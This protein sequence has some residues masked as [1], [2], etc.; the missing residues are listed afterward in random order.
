MKTKAKPP[1]KDQT[2]RN[3]DLGLVGTALASFTS[4]QR[5]VLSGPSSLALC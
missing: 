1:E 5:S 2:R 3:D 4:A